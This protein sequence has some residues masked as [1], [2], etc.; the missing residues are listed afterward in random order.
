MR[1]SIPLLAL[2]SV[3]PTLAAGTGEPPEEG[4]RRGVERALPLLA[5]GAAGYARQRPCF[6]CHHQALPVLALTTAREHGFRVDDELVGDQ[7][8]FTEQS[9]RDGID[10]YQRGDG[11]G[12]GTTT[13]GYALWTLEAGG[14]MPDATTAAVAE[15]LLARDRD[16]GYWR[17]SAN[18]PPSEVSAFTSTY[19]ALRALK[20]FSNPEQQERL[21]DRVARARDWLLKTPAT[22]TED[23]VF[24]LWA[25]RYAQPPGEAIRE[26]AAALR[27]GQREDGGWA[28]L[29]GGEPDAY[30]TGSALAVLHLAGELAVTDP[31]YRRGLAYLLRTQREDGSWLVVSRSKP[32]QP[33]LE[34]GFPHGKDQFISSAATGWAVIALALASGKG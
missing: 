5:R 20:R 6:S 11:Q 13:A 27:K 21:A 25:L 26:A 19:V 22:E 33:Y 9:L 1:I 15:F 32:F 10:A 30:A 7:V 16:R 31:A 4:L 29:D 24:R 12:G 14:R 18:R 23:R 2:L 34:T 8:R 17:T 3:A 28:Q